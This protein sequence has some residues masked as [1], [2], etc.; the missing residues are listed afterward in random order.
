[1]KT[2]TFSH[3]MNE[4]DERYIEEAL[5]Y[6]P[7]SRRRNILK[8]SA[9]AA[10]L[11]IVCAAAVTVTVRFL[12]Q[13]RTPSREPGILAD[14]TSAP[15]T[16]DSGKEVLHIARSDIYLNELEAA[17]DAALRYYDPELYDTVSWNTDDITGYFG[18]DLTPAYIPAG[19]LPAPGNGT[20][21]VIMTKDQT[22]VADT[23]SLSYY[24]AYYEDGSPMLTED[25]A[26]VKGLTIT[27]SRMGLTDTDCGLYI[28]P[29]ND[30]QVSD[31]GGT[32]VTIG[33]RSMEYGPYDPETHEPSGC[34]DLYV[35]EFEHQ[36]IQYR[37]LTEQLELDEL[38]KV[39]ASII[40]G[41]AIV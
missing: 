22:L 41:D 24:H 13:E 33:Y 10:S 36:G 21:E 35:A 8:W 16:M 25:A 30:V 39:T 32:A 23:V 4:I 28:L 31:I 5:H 7:I 18:T 40:Q 27:A 17:P 37:I 19:L 12:R 34:Y 20:A 2:T 3:A 26:A 14:D 11:L 9:A 38:L 15:S 29:E 1:M 6:K